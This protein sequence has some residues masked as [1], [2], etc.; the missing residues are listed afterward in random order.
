MKTTVEI[1]ARDQVSPADQPIYD[2]LHTWKKMPAAF[3]NQWNKILQCIEYKVT[4][5]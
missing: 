3:F 2:N 1:P 4:Q 5:E